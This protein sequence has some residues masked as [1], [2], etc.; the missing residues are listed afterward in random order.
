MRFGSSYFRN[1]LSGLGAD[2]QTLPLAD[3]AL[4]ALVSGGPSLVYTE[5]ATQTGDT[6]WSEVTPSQDYQ[7]FP[8]TDL[9]L[10]SVASTAS[11]EVQELAV[12]SP[13]LTSMA[14]LKTTFEGTPFA[15]DHTEAVYAQ[16][17][18]ASPPQIYFLYWLKLRDQSDPKTGPTS[19]NYAA[20]MVGGVLTYIAPIAPAPS[21]RP[22]PASGSFPGAFTA[23]VQQ[24]PI[25]IPQTPAVQTTIPTVTQAPLPPPV[26]I[27]TAPQQASLAPSAASSNARALLWVGLGTAAAIGAYRFIQSRKKAS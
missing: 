23:Q 10:V 11:S 26:T 9:Q 15:Y 3:Q 2:D 17:D 24:G 20:T 8:I 12:I 5:W 19:L 22:H 21:D 25:T 1:D 14:A 27:T 4:L 6:A 13:V 16:I 18:Q 7:A